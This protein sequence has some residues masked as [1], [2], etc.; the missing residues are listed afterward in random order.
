MQES[1]AQTEGQQRETTAET[2]APAKSWRCETEEARS[3]TQPFGM[4]CF[5]L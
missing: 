5:F 1:E 3:E 4:R 2:G